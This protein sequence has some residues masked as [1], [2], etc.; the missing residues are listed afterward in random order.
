MTDNITDLTRLI[1]LNPTN[2]DLCK[3]LEERTETLR[4]CIITGGSR[5]AKIRLIDD[6]K[7]LSKE[8]RGR[9]LYENGENK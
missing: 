2:K 7:T 6:L 5:E 1:L 3:H 4:D 8:I 9:L